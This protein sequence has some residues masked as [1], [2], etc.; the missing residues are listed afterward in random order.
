VSV[1]S[2]GPSNLTVTGIAL[3]LVAIVAVVVLATWAAHLTKDAL[4]LTIMPTNEQQ[5]HRTLMVG[6]VAY[7]GLLAIPFVSGVEQE[8]QD[9]AVL[10]LVALALDPHLA[11]VLG[12][13]FPAERDEIVCRKSSRPG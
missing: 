4:D 7:I 2:Q 3:R 12:G 10:H 11:R 13:L 6:L 9:V 5:V 1:P 8:V